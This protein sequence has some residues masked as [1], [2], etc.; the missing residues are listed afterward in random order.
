[1]ITQNSNTGRLKN[2]KT[3]NKKNKTKPKTPSAYYRCEK[4]QK[5]V[6]TAINSD[7]MAQSV[8]AEK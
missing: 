3:K 2:K 7:I 4:L 8:E 1:M 6:K 5:N